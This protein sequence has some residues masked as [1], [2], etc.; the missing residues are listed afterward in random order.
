MSNQTENNVK[1][2]ILKHL[3]IIMDGNRRWAKDRG[4]LPWEGHQAAMPLVR[5]MG[6]WCLDRGIEYLTFFAFSTENWKRTQPEVEML[7]G[8]FYTAV[9]DEVDTYMERNVRLKIVG[10]REGLSQKLIDAITAAEER[11]SG[12][13]GG[14]ISLCINYG[15]RPEII[16]ATKEA[17]RRGMKPEDITEESLHALMWSKDLPD[18]DLIIRTSGEQ[19]LSGYLTWLSVYSELLFIEKHWP[20]FT[21]ADLDAALAEYQARQRRFGK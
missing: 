10:G 16:E 19:R 13:T 17:I 15:G 11:T 2:P 1:K 3:A 14:T 12:N 5:N 4:L 8:L 20:D 6:Q 7:M 9:T 18:A 21:E